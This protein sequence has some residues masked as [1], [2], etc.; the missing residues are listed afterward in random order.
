M[1]CS[2]A[3]ASWGE[4]AAGTARVF[5]DTLMKPSSTIEHVAHP[6]DGRDLN[7]ACAWVCLLYNSA[8]M[9]VA[10]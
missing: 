2:K 9:T 1:R 5:E 3:V 7:H 8:G 10:G 6:A 4:T